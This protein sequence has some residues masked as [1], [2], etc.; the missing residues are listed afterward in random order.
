MEKNSPVNPSVAELTGK[1]KGYN[2]STPTGIE[3]IPVRRRPPCSLQLHSKRAEGHNEEE[4]P[5]TVSPHPPKVKMRSS[6][7][8]EKLQANL[9]LAP[10]ALLPP[11]KSPEVK[12]HPPPLSPDHGLS[13]PN[14][15][16]SPCSPASSSPS[17]TLS[18]SQHTDEEAPVSFE[19]PPEGTVLPSFNKGRARLS[20]K[21]RL[22]TRQHR[23]SGGKEPGAEGGRASPCPSDF[24]HHSGGEEEGSKMDHKESERGQGSS[25]SLPEAKR[26]AEKRDSRGDSTGT[27]PPDEA[28]R[29]ASDDT[30]EQVATTE[31]IKPL[32]SGSTVELQREGEG[33]GI[34]VK[35][36]PDDTTDD[37]NR[38]SW[39]EEE[40][41]QSQEEEGGE[42]KGIT[43]E[44]D[45][46]PRTGD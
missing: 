12:L 41:I 18:P 29:S 35:P 1:F 26:Q 16:L 19:N 28:R 21:R 32:G 36:H 22:P 23:K 2:M 25:S 13:P 4:K 31:E 20:I 45:K 24:Q 33:E 10:T 7:L 30:E 46:P 38:A 17:P 39:K 43:R 8:I 37:R 5:A 3:E 40:E 27:G 15:T 6:P 34:Q 9:T 42:K 14:H 44:K 11:P